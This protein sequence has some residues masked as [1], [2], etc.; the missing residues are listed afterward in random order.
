MAATTQVKDIR[1]ELPVAVKGGT[2]AK[3]VWVIGDEQF[4][5]IKPLKK[6][7]LL[8]DERKARLGSRQL[9]KYKAGQTVKGEDL[10]FV[11]IFA[12]VNK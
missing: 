2:A 9:A 4:K 1:A 7:G 12:K 11:G 5:F 6:N 10:M 3:P 8:P